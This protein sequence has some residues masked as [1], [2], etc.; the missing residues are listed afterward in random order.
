MAR[1]VEGVSGY[2]DQAMGL[3]GAFGGGTIAAVVALGVASRGSVGSNKVWTSAWVHHTSLELAWTVAPALLILV[4]VSQ[5]AACLY[6][7]ESQRHTCTGTLGIV[8]HQWYWEYVQGGQGAVESRANNTL[9]VRQAWT[10]QPAYLP[11]GVRTGLVLSSA[12]VIHAWWVPSLGVKVDTVPGRSSLSGVQP[13]VEGV[14]SGWCAELCGSGHG[15]M[16]IQVVVYDATTE[17]AGT[18]GTGH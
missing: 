10:D 18:R 8:A 9:G 1:G 7:I 3:Y 17:G 13:M 6:A 16:P 14:T 2:L 4:T 5:S 15:F 11:L 12:D